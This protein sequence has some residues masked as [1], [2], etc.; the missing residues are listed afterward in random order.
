MSHRLQESWARRAAEAAATMPRFS[1][2]SERD[3]RQEAALWDALI[4]ALPG[5]PVN[6]AWRDGAFVPYA[7]TRV[8][9]VLPGPVAPVV[10]DFAEL[11]ALAARDPESFTAPE[12]AG[13]TFTVVFAPEV[14]AIEPLLVPRQAAVLGVGR[15]RLTLACDARAVSYA[16][17]AAF[18]AGLTRG[19]SASGRGR[20]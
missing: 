19:D 11:A 2:L 5:S 10:G 8:A 4:A 3:T 6:G 18:L 1:V 7:E 17:A 9:V 15:T 16:G 14:E 13:A 20:A 12:L